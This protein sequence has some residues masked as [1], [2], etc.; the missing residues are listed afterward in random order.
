MYGQYEVVD[1]DNPSTMCFLK[2][3]G[4]K[5]GARAFVALNFTANEQ[6]IK[7]P[8]GEWQLGIAGGSAEPSGSEPL[9]AYEGRIYLSK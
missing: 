7:M 1:Y 2:T 5:S 9:T 3:A 4:D 8:A 6:P